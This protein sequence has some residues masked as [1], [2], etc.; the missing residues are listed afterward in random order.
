MNRRLQRVRQFQHT[1][2]ISKIKPTFTP[3]ANP[4]KCSAHCHYCSEDLQI[5]HQLANSH[6][7]LL[8]KENQYDTY[9]QKLD[10]C[11][12]YI[13]E[14]YGKISLSL[15]GLEAT[16]EKK[17]L[18]RML[19][20]VEKKDHLFGEKAL[21]TNGTNFQ[22]QNFQ[23]FNRIELHRDHYNESVNTKIMRI[24]RSYAIQEN[25]YFEKLFE[26][27]PLD[28][29]LWL[30]CILSQIGVKN[31]QDID[32]YTKWAR[33]IGARGVIFRELSLFESRSYEAN[34]ILQWVDRHRVSLDK[35]IF[36]LID[37]GTETTSGQRF[38]LLDVELGYYYFNEK[39]LFNDIEVVF[40]TSTYERL[41]QLEAQGVVHKLVFYSNYRLCN[42]WNPQKNILRTF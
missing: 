28:H 41:A 37:G 5:K 34:K 20:L 12:E 11:L 26:N 3:Y 7:S 40:E 24:E 1:F 35:D 31:L 6:S 29:H 23:N 19:E 10:E 21:Y 13:F 4:M 14:K 25:K 18:D 36:P 15:S 42:G 32:E 38:E 16:I 39:Y 8:I 30:V 22:Y 17:W 9:F 2:D 33:S 27:L